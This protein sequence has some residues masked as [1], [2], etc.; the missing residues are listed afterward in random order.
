[1]EWSGIARKPATFAQL[2]HT[3]ETSRFG[4]VGQHLTRAGPAARTDAVVNSIV[5]KRS[6]TAAGTCPS[7][8]P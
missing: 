2:S 6:V 5:R 4:V 8:S 3:V 7:G 1:M